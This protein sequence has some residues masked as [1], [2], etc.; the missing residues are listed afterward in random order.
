M[1]LDTVGGTIDVQ[2]KDGRSVTIP[3]DI[4]LIQA[5][6]K[7]GGPKSQDGGTLP[8]TRYSESEAIQRFIN[9]QLGYDWPEPKD[10]SIAAQVARSAGMKRVLDTILDGE[11]LGRIKVER[12]LT[13]TGTRPLFSPVVEAGIRLGLNRVEA[14]WQD[15]IA[16]TIPVDG[17]T[18][19]YYEFNNGTLDG[20]S[21]TGVEEFRLRR[22]AQ[23]GPIPTARV[24]IGQKNLTLYKQGRGIEWTDESKSAPIDLAAM[25]FQQVG[26]QLGWDYHE[27]IIDVLLN[28]YFAD[29]SD[30]APVLGSL[31]PGTIDY[32]D[33]LTAQGT[34]QITYGYTADVMLASLAR[35]VSIRTMENGA[36]QLVFPNG[37][38]AAG[39]PPLRIATG[40]PDD[41]VLLV[42]RGF[43]VVRYVNKEFGTEFD[44]SV[45]TQVEGSYGTSIELT[46]PGFPNARLVLDS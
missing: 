43:A 1:S 24:T 38:E 19:E 25:W 37:V 29:G 39:L 44:R 31:V 36:G 41:K 12:F 10:R 5:A 45:Q 9:K 23:G 35:S 17:M 3:L 22:I 27:Q 20:T 30:D 46:V 26:L 21:V 14:L 7:T 34:M 8:P 4:A 28:G 11:D 18:Y 2:H 15:L 33:L 16:Q 32:A 6:R 42:D 40:I 13:N